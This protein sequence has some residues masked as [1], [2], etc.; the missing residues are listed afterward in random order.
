MI[1][2][3]AILVL[4]YSVVFLREK[5]GISQTLA[6]K[7][8]IAGAISFTTFN[9]GYQYFRFVNLSPTE[10]I[11]YWVKGQNSPYYV[12]RQWNGASWLDAEQVNW[13]TT[14]FNTKALKPNLSSILRI[15]DPGYRQYR[16]GIICWDEAGGIRDTVWSTMISSD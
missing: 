13:C 7:S 5:Q 1:R 4:I 6:P 15:P 8:K 10:P 14:G 3:T 11:I 12:I 9:Y 2:Y 16:I